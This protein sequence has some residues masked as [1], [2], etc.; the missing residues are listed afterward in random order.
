[1][2]EQVNQRIE[3]MINELEQMRRTQMYD[4]E[5]IK[6][7][8]RK[9]KEFEYHIQRRVKQKEDFVQYIAYELA[10]LEDISL[11]RQQAKLSEKKKDI[12]Y[13]I[14]KRVNKVFK[15]FIYR[16][17]DDLE[18]YFEYIKFCQSVGFDYAISGIIGQML[19][20]HGD[21]PKIWQLASKWESKEQNNL[22]N[23][24]NFL[25]KGVHRH[26]ES[27]ILYLE[28]FD[29]ELIDLTFKTGDEEDREKQVKRADIV[30]K[31]G[32]KNI[33]SPKFL[34]NVFDLC[35]KYEIKESFVDDIKKEIWLRNDSKDVWSYI[36]AKELEGCHWE[37]IEEFVDEEN[38]FSKEV[39]NYI[40]VYEEALQKFPD[41]TLC[42]KYIHDLLGASETVCS[43]QQK[44]SAVKHAWKYGYENGLLTNEMFAFGL[45]ILKL[46]NETSDEEL[47][48]IL[49]SAIIMNPK[50]RCVWEEKILLCK[51]D[52]KKMLSV[53]QAV[54]GLKSDDLL[55]IYN[56]VLDN[57]ETDVALKN[58][59]KKFQSCENAVL[60]AIKPK[61]LQKMY[62]KNGLKAARDLYEDLIR[63]PPTQI[64]VHTNM[65]D[66]EMLQE[67]PN[68]KYI[69]KC[70]ECAVQHH[71]TDNVDLWV[72]YMEF[73]TDHNAQAT[74]A[75]YRRA[76]GT[77]K[78]EHVDQFIRAQTLAKIK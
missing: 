47:M 40:G 10:L 77:L 70:Y 8:S 65:I 31:N 19:Q 55:H 32:A 28:L 75:I 30:W 3:D 36:A 48:E 56:V 58:L 20:I 64:E 44:I 21:K 11:R 43:D 59:Y 38:N 7:I 53:L 54:K 24:R 60:L 29:I 1:M 26:P 41:E 37:E 5:E 51:S 71:G 67:K 46:E 50:L 14:A 35:R 63:T 78:K 23:A 61:L 25:L 74:P 13:A 57:V 17:Q 72:K 66:I 45:E 69:R 22:D 9:R 12:E 34:F 6:E 2:A 42:T 18:I 49:D 27:E 73:E 4:D 39:N 16:F 76:V 15:Q 62:E 52:E 33:K 68:P